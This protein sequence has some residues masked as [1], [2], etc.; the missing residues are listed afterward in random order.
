MSQTLKLKE[1]TEL[2]TN[3]FKENKFALSEKIC[4]KLLAKVPNNPRVNHLLGASLI[5]QHKTEEAGPFLRRAL[6]ASGGKKAYLNTYGIWMLRSGR[7][8]KA[9]EIFET[10]LR[11]DPDFAPAYTNIGLV[12]QRRSHFDAAEIA[13]RKALELKPEYR[14]A[15]HNLG[16][17]LRALKRLDEAEKNLSLALSMKPNDDEIRMD[18]G[19][20]RLLAGN[21]KEGWE[22][23]EARLS[24]QGER[25]RHNALTIPYWN[26]E[27]F[28]GKRLLIYNEQGFGDLIQCARFFPMVKERGGEVYFAG[29][30]PILR[31]FE[32]AEGIDGIEKDHSKFEEFDLRLPIFSLPR[33]FAVDR[34]NVPADV[35]YLSYDPEVE[36]VTKKS[37]PGAISVGL[38]W[39]GNPEN[40]SDPDRSMP[41]THI[42]DIVSIEGIDFYSLQFGD[43]RAD[44]YEAGLQERITILDDN[45]LG[46]FY[47]MG[48]I[49]KQMDLV[50]SVDT[51]VCHLAGALN[52]PT[53]LMLA[54]NNDW[55]WGAEGSKSP[56]YPSITIFRQQ[57][58]R[59]WQSVVDA[60][61]RELRA[62]RDG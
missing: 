23:Y 16:N 57:S 51:V 29:P 53:L 56:W 30:D 43:R 7:Y 39:A 1:A 40:K 12:H 15:I 26:G 14:A 9:M 33:I 19:I 32:V 52:I 13:H 24:S 21:Y 45:Q 55:R 34:D 35:P 49:L 18:R 3:Y 5:K 17:T 47:R 8:D 61:G 42:K 41:G 27:E 4:R 44:L 20:C 62:K 22:D 46:D 31:L 28:E 54:T 37:H 6:K 59:E 11:H 58:P 38:C 10:I 25:A 48:N 36:T 50:V 2:A 60:I